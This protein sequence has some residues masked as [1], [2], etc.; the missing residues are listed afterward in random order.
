[1]RGMSWTWAKLH[2]WTVGCTTA[3]IA[4]HSFATTV[5]INS[6]TSKKAG[7]EIGNGTF[8]MGD[9]V[10]G[11]GE[12]S[13]PNAVRDWTP[14]YSDTYTELVAPADGHSAMPTTLRISL[15]ALDQD[16]DQLKEL[17]ELGWRRFNW[18]D[19]DGLR[20]ERLHSRSKAIRALEVKLFREA[21]EAIE[22]VLI[23]SKKSPSFT[24]LYEWL[25]PKK[26]TMGETD[27]P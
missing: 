5:S 3:L 14:R 8:E 16:D 23:G 22:L 7:V 20:L 4:S 24:Y 27:N 9:A 26:E 17:E 13:L 1:M 18:A 12:V 2:L 25:T 6:Q 15:K 21:R 11:T 10:N 19:M